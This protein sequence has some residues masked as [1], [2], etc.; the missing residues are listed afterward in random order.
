[1]ILCTQ[2]AKLNEFYAR[3]ALDIVKR[4]PNETFRLIADIKGISVPAAPA[5]L[6]KKVIS[7]QIQSHLR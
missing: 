5:R 3:S 2:R 4:W 7:S 1:L 6:P